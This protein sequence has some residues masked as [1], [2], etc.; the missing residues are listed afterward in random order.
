MCLNTV[1]L[2]MIE[3]VD[4]CQNCWLRTE[5]ASSRCIPSAST[6]FQFF[7]SD[8]DSNVIKFDEWSSESP[9]Q[10]IDCTKDYTSIYG[11]SPITGPPT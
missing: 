6:G 5:L 9:L 8:V 10:E 1:E 3:E 4:V 11:V 2:E 7:G